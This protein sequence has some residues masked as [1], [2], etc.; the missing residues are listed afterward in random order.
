MKIKRALS[1]RQPFAE[2]IMAGK[3]KWEYRGR[4]TNI[5]ERIYIYASRKPGPNESW[6]K[7]SRKPGELPV[8]VLVGSV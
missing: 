4:P 2:Q 5:R 7:I 6:K 1:I 3:K 8:G